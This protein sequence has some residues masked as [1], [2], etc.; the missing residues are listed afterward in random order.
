M[1]PAATPSEM[2]IERDKSFTAFA[3]AD[4]KRLTAEIAPEIG[5][6]AT[7]P[8]W[9]VGRLDRRA[10]RPNE[11]G[12]EAQKSRTVSTTPWVDVEEGE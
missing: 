11:P 9:S 2:A 1:S 6:D 5:V 7:D 8:V 3:P 10:E 4:L 12:G